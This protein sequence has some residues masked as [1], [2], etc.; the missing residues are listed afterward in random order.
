MS[1]SDER[2][3][4]C[5]KNG[6]KSFNFLYAGTIT[7]STI[8]GKGKK[9]L[10]KVFEANASLMEHV[11]VFNSSD[12]TA[13][14]IEKARESLFLF[15]QVATNYNISLEIIQYFFFQ[16]SFKKISSKLE[17]FPPTSVSGA[18]HSFRT[19]Y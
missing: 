11:R 1:H 14:E 7:T 18:Q 16:K 3:Y 8:Y 10:L 4:I 12:S 17:S 5:Y 13:N 2:K 15:L 9:Q 19:Y 6:T